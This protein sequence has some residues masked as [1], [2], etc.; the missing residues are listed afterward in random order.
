L[1]PIP[2]TFQFET[3]ATVFVAVLRARVLASLNKN[4]D[5][6]AIAAIYTIAD[7]N[8]VSVI[9]AADANAIAAIYTIADANVA[10]V[11]DAADANVVSDRFRF[12][13][14]ANT[15]AHSPSVIAIYAF[16]L[17]TGI[18]F[19]VEDCNQDTVP[20]RFLVNLFLARNL[21]PCL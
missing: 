1:H 8:A 16:K 3:C 17:K 12:P 6:A 20:K 9:D 7:A 14:A 11:C 19:H 5:S 4:T 10:S 13:I 2:F 15:N 18:G 21:R